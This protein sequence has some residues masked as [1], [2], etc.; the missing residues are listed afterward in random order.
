[1]DTNLDEGVAIQLKGTSFR[2]FNETENIFGNVNLTINKNQHTIITGP[3]GSGKSTLLALFSG[4]IYPSEGVVA[5]H[6]DKYSYVSATPM[7]LNST[8]RENL[9]YGTKEKVNEE[10]LIKLISE[11][12]LFNEEKDVSLDKSVSNKMLSTGQM[13]KISF[14]RALLSGSEI[15]LLDES[16]SNLDYETKIQIFNIL[17][18]RKLTIVNATHNPEEFITFDQHIEIVIENGDRKIVNSSK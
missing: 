1:L 7:I 6:T 8:L 14:I 13:Q 3:N 10:N 17:A 4:I 11:F 12:N 2:Y 9:L 18:K 15:L 5:S 16:T